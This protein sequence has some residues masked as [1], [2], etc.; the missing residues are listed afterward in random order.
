[1]CSLHLTP[2][3]R[4]LAERAS[5]HDHWSSVTWQIRA[6]MGTCK[7]AKEKAQ[8]IKYHQNPLGAQNPQDAARLKNRLKHRGQLTLKNRKLEGFWF[9]CVCVIKQRLGCVIFGSGVVAEEVQPQGGMLEFCLAWDRETQRPTAGPGRQTFRGVRAHRGHL[10]FCATNTVAGK[11]LLV[12]NTGD[13]W[14]MAYMS[15]VVRQ[16][17]LRDWSF[18]SHRFQASRELNVGPEEVKNPRK[19]FGF[20]QRLKMLHQAIWHSAASLLFQRSDLNSPRALLSLSRF[21]FHLLNPLSS[22]ST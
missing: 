5:Q 14:H 1:M 19:H 4:T 9:Q 2:L 20:L 13:P 10:E 3:G 8:E 17:F 7:W 21:L 16:C 22:L 12:E 18:K 11:E 6:W 15:R